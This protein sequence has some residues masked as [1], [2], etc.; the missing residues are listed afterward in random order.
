VIIVYFPSL[1]LTSPDRFYVPRPP[2]PP[3]KC[4]LMLLYSNVK[5]CTTDSL[6]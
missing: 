3:Q 2:P 1:T 5:E 4:T 6:N